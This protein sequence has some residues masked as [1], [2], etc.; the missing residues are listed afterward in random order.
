MKQDLESRLQGDDESLAKLFHKTL[1]VH[2]T[3][4]KNFIRV[5]NGHKSLDLQWHECY[6][7]NSTDHRTRYNPADGSHRLE[8]KF[9]YRRMSNRE[10]TVKDCSDMYLKEA[11]IASLYSRGLIESPAR[12]GAAYMEEKLD[13]MPNNCCATKDMTSLIQ[14]MMQ[15][16]SLAETFCEK[17]LD[18]NRTDLTSTQSSGSQQATLAPLRHIDST[19]PDSNGKT[20]VADDSVIE[21]DVDLEENPAPVNTVTTWQ[22]RMDTNLETMTLDDVALSDD[23]ENELGRK[24]DMSRTHKLTVPSVTSIE[25]SGEPEFLALIRAAITDNSTRKDMLADLVK[26]RSKNDRANAQNSIGLSLD[27]VQHRIV[28][29]IDEDGTYHDI[30]S[31]LR[32]QRIDAGEVAQNQSAKSRL[33]RWMQRSKL[34]SP[35]QMAATDTVVSSGSVWLTIHQDNKLLFVKVL[36]ALKQYRGGKKPC[37]DVIL[38]DLEIAQVQIFDTVVE[39]TFVHD[40]ITLINTAQQ[41]LYQIP[42]ESIEHTDPYCFRFKHAEVAKDIMKQWESVAKEYWNKIVMKAAHNAG[43]DG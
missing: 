21:M 13:E 24:M 1:R 29:A 17:F 36:G 12:K 7:P 23:E 30:G 34:S 6:G 16:E 40:E 22:A 27:A 18:I 31:V 41:L 42:A 39:G 25:S 4:A 5:L 14:V 26:I 20:Y 35:A 8:H 3:P 19:I 28:K 10:F 15:A 37:K 32:Q 38:K 33:G 9:G 43:D 11:A 2:T